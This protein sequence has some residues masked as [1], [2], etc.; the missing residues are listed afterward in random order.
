MPLPIRNHSEEHA[1]EHDAQHDKGLRQTGQPHALARQ[2]PFRD[3]GGLKDTLVELRRLAI[4]VTS[5]GGIAIGALVRGGGREKDVCQGVP[6]SA[7]FAEEHQHAKEE[8]VPA[9]VSD[10]GDNRIRSLRGWIQC[11]GSNSQLLAI[12]SHTFDSA[13]GWSE[14]TINRKYV[15][16]LLKI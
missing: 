13:W 9:K 4:F 10:E 2:I 6:A 1:T 3:D 15:F 16:I 5:I 11:H 14:Y 12:R 8:L 7:E